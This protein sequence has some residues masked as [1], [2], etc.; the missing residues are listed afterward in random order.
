MG[1]GSQQASSFEY[2]LEECRNLFCE[3]L[4]GAIAGMLE[5]ADESL[6]EMTT[7]VQNREAQ[8]TYQETRKVLSAQ[9]RTLETKFYESYLKEFQ[10]HTSKLKDEGQSFSEIDVSL[11]LVG[12]DDLADDL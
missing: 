9:R 1:E 7:R 11:E 2:L 12:D 3:R 4:R 10:A 8:Q 6:V 5:K